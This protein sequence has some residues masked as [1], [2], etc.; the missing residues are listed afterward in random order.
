M[1][2]TKE[3]RKEI[4]RLA[5]RLHLIDLSYSKKHGYNAHGMC[6]DLVFAIV[7][8]NTITTELSVDD[9][10]I[11]LVEF[12]KL[13]PIGKAEDEYWWD[14]KDYEIRKQMYEKYLI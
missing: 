1:K 4:Y 9:I 11:Q 13:Q 5:Y 8:L 2:L 10:K 6:E 12:Y 14:R 7:E 3:Q